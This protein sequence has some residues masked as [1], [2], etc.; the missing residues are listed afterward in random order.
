LLVVDDYDLILVVT[1]RI[2]ELAGALVWVA[3]NGQD[4]YETLKRQPSH[5]DVVLMDVQMPIMD[6]YEAT[7][8]IR[9]DLG[10]LDLPI[11]ALT[12]GALSSERQRAMAVGMHG[13]VVKPFDAATLISSVLHSVSAR[14]PSRGIL[15]ARHA[16]NGGV[17]WPEVNGIDMAVAR[18]R[19]CDDPGL[20]RELLQ[21]FLID[22]SDMALPSPRAMDSSLAEQA[23]RLHKLR[24]GACILGAKVIE[25]LAAAAEAACAAGDA[26]GARDGSLQ[27]VAQLAELRSSAARAFEGA[28]PEEAP[29]LAPRPVGFEPQALAKTELGVPS[30][31]GRFG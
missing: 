10:L 9:A 28:R 16:T 1:R 2:L 31:R 6:G 25:H 14:G 7:R 12:A 4:A 11:I 29:P 15:S 23:S 22:F 3:N 20:F 17:A 21:R 24:G 26:A 19:L 30:V 5:F 8:R 27:L 18:N 13:F